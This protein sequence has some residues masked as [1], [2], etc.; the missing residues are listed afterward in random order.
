M[1]RSVVVKKNKVPETW[2]RWRK[3]KRE[4]HDHPVNKV[5]TARVIRRRWRLR[6]KLSIWR[7]AGLDQIFMHGEHLWK[8]NPGEK[9]RALNGQQHRTKPRGTASEKNRGKCTVADFFFRSKIWFG[10]GERTDGPAWGC[11][12]RRR[13]RARRRASPRPCCAHPV[14]RANL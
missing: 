1:C 11:R 8:R 13:R 12:N 5:A 7:A 2:R 10:S 6:N 14:S 9:T 4:K 3:K